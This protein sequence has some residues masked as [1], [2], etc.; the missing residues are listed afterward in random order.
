[1]TDA[2]DSYFAALAALRLRALLRAD[3]WAEEGEGFDL[4]LAAALKVEPPNADGLD[5]PY[6]LDRRAMA[7]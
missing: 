6:F 3:R 5:I 2:H 7:A 1:M 4:V